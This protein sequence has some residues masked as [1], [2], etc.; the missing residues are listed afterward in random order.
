MNLKHLVGSGDRIGLFTLPFAVA[1]VAFNLAFPAAFAVGGPP[2]WLMAV[3]A[4]VGAAG[5]AIWLWSVVLILT[6]VPRGRLI[7]TGPYALVKH[8]L[9]TAVSLLVLPWLGFMLNTWV[10]AAIG[11]VLFAGSRM[12]ARSEEEELARTFG[13]R[14]DRYRRSVK[15]AWL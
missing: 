1:G 4:V 10:G 15:L 3:S 8:P 13:P 7:T 11:V 5:I 9:Y 12:F 6:Y 14:W 2:A